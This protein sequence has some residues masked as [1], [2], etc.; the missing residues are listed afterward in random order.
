VRRLLPVL[1]AIAAGLAA[2]GWGLWTLERI[3]GRE[4]SEALAARDAERAALVQCAREALA[5]TLAARLRDAGPR[6]DAA[7]DDP[8][9]PD[10]GLYLSVGGDVR[11]P[12]LPVGPAAPVGDPTAR[13]ECSRQGT[14]R[15][16]AA[17][18]PWAERVALADAFG[19]AL[20]R[21]DAA[22]VEDAFRALLAHRLRYLLDPALD[23]PLT[24]AAVERL[25]GRADPDL[26]RQV[27]RDGVR[28]RD[29]SVLPGLQRFLLAH[30]GRFAPADLRALGDRLAA[31]S[32]AA[33]VP[34]DDFAARLAETPQPAPAP[35][36][37]PALVGGWYV[38]PQGRTLRGLAVDAPA[39]PATLT[40]DLRALGLLQPEDA[41]TAAALEGPLARLPLA[42]SAPR[43]DRAG[44]EAD[45]RF[46]LKTALAALCGVFGL[47]IAALALLFQRRR[48][49]TLAL[50]SE[51]VAT[52]SHELRTPLA[53]IRLLAETLARRLRGVPEAG[54]YPARIV[55]DVEGLAF[56]VENVLSYNR[57]GRVRP[58]RRPLALAG[59]VEAVRD[60]VE[61]HA[62]RPIEWRLEG[63]DGVELSADPDLLH[64][65]LLNLARN[66]C[67]HNERDPVRIGVAARADDAWVEVRVDDNGVGIPPVERRRVFAAFHR[68]GGRGR[69]AG[70]GLALCRRVARAHGGTLRVADSGPDGTTFALRLPRG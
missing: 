70:L 42:V 30:R 19:A 14:C 59:L 48:Q 6:F 58:R 52:V 67:Q 57:V 29:G 50:Q 35:T 56:L 47:A 23:V 40:A 54:D 7:L 39:L 43:L 33:G 37:E 22:A 41:V 18:G 32:R 28:A 53:S 27:L 69:G 3:F 64:L 13:Y 63:L 51:L 44:A 20:R 4:R 8:L 26:L 2:L 55:R 16:A 65:L 49:R 1:L 62:R 10:S 31:L 61:A 38:E 25:A 34:A 60:D 11:L 68:A 5:R 66:A 24:L 12:R 45:A 17:P 21:G 9:A 36:A 46:R 15:E